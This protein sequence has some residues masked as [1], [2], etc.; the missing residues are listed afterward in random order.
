MD[1]AAQSVFDAINLDNMQVFESTVRPDDLKEG[2]IV[3]RRKLGRT[4]WVNLS[5]ANHS[6]WAFKIHDASNL[7]ILS[8]SAREF[9]LLRL[10]ESS[11]L[12]K[13]YLNG[14]EMSRIAQ[15]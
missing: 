7:I 5:P 9:H 11:G 12:I 2:R 4:V 6:R 14:S 13:C 15:F 1:N 10:V 8:H 3:P